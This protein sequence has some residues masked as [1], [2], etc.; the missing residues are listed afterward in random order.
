[1]TRT[2]ERWVRLGRMLWQ[3]PRPHGEQQQDRAVTPLEL[4]YDLVVVVLVAQSA[5]HLAQHLSWAGL[6]EFA[7]VF[8]LVWI[9]WLNGT[10]YHDLHGRE[11]ARGRSALLL[12]VLVLVPL[13]VFIPEAG[14]ARGAAFGVDGAVLFVVL[15]LLWRLASRG[16]RP[17][18]RRPSLLFVAGT[19]VCAVVLAATAFL[20]ASARVL[21]WLLLDLGYLTGFAVLMTVAIPVQ[22]ATLTITD[23]L[24]DRFGQFLIIVL[25]ET[26][27]GVVDGLASK[28]IGPLTL[29]VGLVAVVVGFGAWWTYFDFAGNREARPGRATSMQWMLA[30]LP[31]TAAVAAMGAAMVSLTEH[32]G[33][34]RTPAPTAWMLCGG[35]AVAL[36]SVMVL[37]GSLKAWQEERDLYRR[38][39]PS[40]VIAAAVCAGLGWARPGPL[41]LGILLVICL[42]VPWVVAVGYRLANA[43]QPVP[44]AGAGTGP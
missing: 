29:S 24:I 11:D 10:L 38:L 30:H 32:G 25:G 41:L 34:G 36:C 43:E 8:M 7:A 20:P 9:A 31:L 12:Q 15:A 33:D 2:A 39:A 23:A 40:C 6:R 1:M 17:E 5:R 44:A 37:A 18:Y 27:T 35:T 13:G 19:A 42:S 3:P 28:R 16:D 26:V 21:V 22:A 4:F 14:G